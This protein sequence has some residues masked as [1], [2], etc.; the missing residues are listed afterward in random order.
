M[1]R[2]LREQGDDSHGS[3]AIVARA[4]DRMRLDADD[5]DRYRIELEYPLAGVWYEMWYEL[6]ARGRRSRSGAR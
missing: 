3:G 2:G 1:G 5:F 6:P 4:F